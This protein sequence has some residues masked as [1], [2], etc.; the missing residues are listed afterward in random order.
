MTYNTYNGE[1][2]T[3][4]QVL[5]GTNLGGPYSEYVFLQVHGGCDVRGGYTAPR[6]YST[7]DGWIP[8]ELSF[9][10]QRCE[11]TE[12]ES[13]VYGEESLIYQPTPDYEEIESLLIEQAPEGVSDEEAREAAAEIVNDG[14]GDEH[15]SGAVFHDCDDEGVGVVRF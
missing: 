6:V 2:H 13:C 9:Y 1:C 15:R 4:T 8:H 5:Q 7:F 12:A 11:W 10:C 3:L 14:H